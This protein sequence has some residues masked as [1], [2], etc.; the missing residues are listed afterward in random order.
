MIS[1]LI[2]GRVMP[3]RTIAITA[4]FIAAVVIASALASEST[5]AVAPQQ[6]TGK[7]VLDAVYTQ[8]Q[9]MRGGA[10]FAANCARC[11][12]GF[13]PDGPPLVGPLFIERWREDSLAALLTF[14][15][16]LPRVLGGVLNENEYV[17]VIAYLLQSNEFPSGAQQL[18]ADSIGSVQLVSKGGPKPLPSN[19][20]VE[21]VGC[22]AHD[23][24]DTLTLSQATTPIR[25]HRGI[26]STPEELKAA[27]ARAAGTLNF[28]LQNVQE[29]RPD[30]KPESVTGHKVLA[31]GVLGR[32]GS[33]SRIFVTS[34]EPLAAACT[35]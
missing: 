24:E 31:K 33:G 26:E 10:L 15:T 16:G 21:V 8:D 18:T 34:F 5:L 13:C 9:A 2:K 11:H 1:L 22:F 30:F 12:E 20:L 3:Q 7:T 19:A 29:I 17:D 4:I 25:I 35:P 27:E 14:M 6:T 28:R 23:G 32:Q